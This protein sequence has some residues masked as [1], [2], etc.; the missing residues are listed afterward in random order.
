M[1]SYVFFEVTTVGEASITNAAAIR[2]F[3]CVQ[4]SMSVQVGFA[5]EAFVAVRT[6]I[7]FFPYNVE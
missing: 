3:S 1:C 4:S 6:K 7:R 5:S 2:S